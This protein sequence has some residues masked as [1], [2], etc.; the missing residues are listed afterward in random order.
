MPI[1]LEIKSEI[2]EGASNSIPYWFQQ[3]QLDVDYLKVS[4]GHFHDFDSAGQPA[5]AIFDQRLNF[6]NAL[7]LKLQK[8]GFI[9]GK[10]FRTHIKYMREYEQHGTLWGLEFQYFPQ[11][12]WSLLVGLDALGVDDDRV[13]N[14]DSRFLNQFR[15]N[16]RV[17]GGVS[18]V[19]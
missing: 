15:A 7:Q 12:H 19:F 8:N 18:Y 13:D 3:F 2:F 14:T 1:R 11:K 17:V 6:L 5:G 10:S 16:D 9:F 4:G